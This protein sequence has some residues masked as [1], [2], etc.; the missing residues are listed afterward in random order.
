MRA[1]LAQCF[2]VPTINMASVSKESLHS[3]LEKVEELALPEGEYLT[4][5]AIL[6]KQFEIL[7]PEVVCVHPFDHTIAFAGKRTINIVFTQRIVYRGAPPDTWR[8]SVNGV[9]KELTT[10]GVGELLAALYR[11]NLTKTITLNGEYETTLREYRKW[12]EDELVDDDDDG[13]FED[14]YVFLHMAKLNL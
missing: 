3:V 12:M 11:M 1:W 13:F 6:K 2:S 5:C 10:R 7:P 14:P 9:A 8:F 4:L